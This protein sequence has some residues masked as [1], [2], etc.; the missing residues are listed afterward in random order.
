MFNIPPKSVD[1]KKEKG[2]ENSSYN[3]LQFVTVRPLLVT[4]QAIHAYLIPTN[5]KCCLWCLAIIFQ[6]ALKTMSFG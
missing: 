3:H 4:T 1:M 2:R 5:C 6:G